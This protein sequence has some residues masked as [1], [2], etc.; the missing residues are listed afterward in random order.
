MVS[1]RKETDKVALAHAAE[2]A[3]DIEAAERL[4]REAI[5]EGDAYAYNNP[6]AAIERGWSLA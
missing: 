4:Y 6:R 1:R 5:A 3:G 2:R